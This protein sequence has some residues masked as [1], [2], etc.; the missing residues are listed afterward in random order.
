[1]ASHSRR[2]EAVQARNTS[3]PFLGHEEE[4][5]MELVTTLVL[6]SRGA[7]LTRRGRRRPWE[8]KGA[9]GNIR[10]RGEGLETVPGL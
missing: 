8:Y 7:V 5:E 2:E 9:P 3:K 1:L 6:S 4:K 10:R